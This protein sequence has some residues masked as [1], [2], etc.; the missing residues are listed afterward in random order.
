ECYDRAIVLP[1]SFKSALVPLFAGIPVR[2]GWRGEMRHGLLNDLR[3]LDKEALPL[4]VQRFA[5]LAHPRDAALPAEPP[6]PALRVQAHAALTVAARFG[7][8]PHEGVLA[9]C[10]GAEFGSSKQWPATHYA[11]VAR[12]AI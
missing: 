3:V 2:S 9:L 4:M 11:E 5:A 12:A 10:P 8:S 6:R 1:N 7:L